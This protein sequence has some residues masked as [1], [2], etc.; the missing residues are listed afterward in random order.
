LFD[1]AQ[2]TLIQAPAGFQGD[3]VIPN[4][5]TSI[6]TDAF[7]QC[8]NLTSVAVPDGVTRVSDYAFYQCSS[9]TNVA[10][11][12]SVTNLGSYAFGSCSAVTNLTLSNNLTSI[13]ANAFNSCFNLASVT[14]P[15]SPA[16][17]GSYAFSSCNGLKSAYFYGN[18]PPD[19]GG[20]FSGDPNATVY[21]L[22]GTTGWG[23]KYGG[24][25]TALWNPAGHGQAEEQSPAVAAAQFG[26]VLS[27]PTNAAVVVQACTN[28]SNPVW[29]ALATNILSGGASSF[30]DPQWHSYP[31]RFYRFKL[32]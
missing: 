6:G 32:P 3:F 1:K 20:A 19:A 10:L 13:G 14:I 15:K 24:A 7:Y 22:A 30:G 25:P 2:E 18:A 21:Y 11:P 12:N 9:L 28:L 27:G 31:A 17:L 16:S 8:F 23:T 5:V 4:T 26:F 29:I